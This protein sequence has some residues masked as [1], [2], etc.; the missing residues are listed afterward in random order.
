MKKAIILTAGLLLATQ[1][2]AADSDLKQIM[3]QMKIEFKHAAEAQTTAEM[4][5]P[6]QELTKLVAQAK[7]GEYPPEKQDIY[8][9]GFNKLTV[10]LDKIENELEHDEFDAAKSSLQQVDSLR[11]EYHE[12][13]NP[14]IW[15]RLFG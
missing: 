7:Q 4:Q 1:V 14:S 5:A 6:I 2:F 11:K 12:K 8:L 15:K 3:K 13:R 9:E 10:A